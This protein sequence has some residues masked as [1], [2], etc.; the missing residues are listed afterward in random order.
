MGLRRNSLELRGGVVKFVLSDLACH[1]RNVPSL[2]FHQAAE[3]IRG[4]RSAIRKLSRGRHAGQLRSVPLN[5]MTPWLGLQLE[6][7]HYAQTGVIE[8]D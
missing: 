6:G 1:N 5:E 7:L 2:C 4:G 3:A 8:Q